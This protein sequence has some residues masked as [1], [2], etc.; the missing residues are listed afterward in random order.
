MNFETL[1]FGFALVAGWLGV[2]AIGVAATEITWRL[3]QR[4]VG[5]SRI[6]KS[7][8]AAHCIK[9]DAGAPPSKP[10][11]MAGPRSTWT[12]LASATSPAMAPRA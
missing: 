9:G 8:R 12:A 4:I 3:Y 1:G 2:V 11:P 5:L 7:V 6:I 10:C